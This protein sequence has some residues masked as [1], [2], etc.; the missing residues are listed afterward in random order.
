MSGYVQPQLRCFSCVTIIIQYICR[1]RVDSSTD[2]LQHLHARPE[3]N[4]TV[5]SACGD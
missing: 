1:K 4:A 5:S 2:S 3:N